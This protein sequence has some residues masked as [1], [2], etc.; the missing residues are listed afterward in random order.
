MGLFI[1]Y[2]FA[3]TQDVTDLLFAT[4][5]RKTKTPEVVLSRC[6]G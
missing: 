2:A 3:F 6:R 1:V 4:H 5:T